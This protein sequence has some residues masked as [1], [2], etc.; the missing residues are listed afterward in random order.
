MR[1]ILVASLA[2]LAPL[3]A[4]A[5]RTAEPSRVGAA[6]RSAEEQIRRLNTQE[7]NALMHHDLRV[8]TTIWSDDMVVTNPVN[9]FVRRDQV[10]ALV[11]SGFIAFTSYDRRVE[12][13]RV[14]GDAAVAAGSET[15]VWAG[16]NSAAGKTS[17]LRFTSVWTR[18]DGQWRE[19]ARHAN[20]VGGAQLA[21]PQH[22]GQAR[23]EGSNVVN[24]ITR[25]FAFEIPDTIPAGL[26]TFRLRN[27]GKQP[28]H[29]MLYRLDRGKTLSAAVAALWAGGAHPVW[30]HAAGGPNAVPPGGE[31]NGTVVLT[32]GRYIAFCHVKSPDNR[33]HFMKGMFK[34]VIVTP[35]PGAPAPLPAA[36]LTVMLRDYSFT[37]SRPP[38]RGHHVIA[39]TNAGAQR[40]ELILSRLRPGKSTRDFVRWIDTQNGPP[41]VMPFGGITD[42]APGETMVIQVDLAPGNYSMVCRVRD[43]GDDQPHDRHGML[44]E[45][46]V[47]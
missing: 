19:V 28:H 9:R 24:V 30:M 12:Y 40:H 26:T 20:V 37:F 33:V 22:V 46:T 41:P 8:L 17:E 4:Q 1:W 23:G 36:D 15:V 21:A 3:T 27:E 6:Q 2:C 34:E 35:S 38:T 44:A 11:K 47:R 18:Q 43:A 42:I 25:E 14:Y 16:S 39:V 45:F 7:V 10:V 32:P 13:V 29:L 5:Q 31:S